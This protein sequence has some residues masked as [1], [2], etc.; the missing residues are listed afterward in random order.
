M[1][2]SFPKP[3]SQHSNVQSSP[4]IHIR[5]YHENKIGSIDGLVHSYFWKPK[6]YTLYAS[7]PKLCMHIYIAYCTSFW[8]FTCIK[9]IS[10]SYSF[11]LLTTRITIFCTRISVVGCY[12]NQKQHLKL[13][14]FVTIILSHTVIKRR[15]HDIVK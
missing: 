5:K 13:V 1:V 7:F 9:F 15:L 11:T 6:M 3:E 12:R 4:W 14:N 8:Y 2:S 10:L